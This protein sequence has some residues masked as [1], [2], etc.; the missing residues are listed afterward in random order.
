MTGSWECH[1]FEHPCRGSFVA[2]VYSYSAGYVHFSSV[3]PL[4]C[5][6]TR[7]VLHGTCRGY[8]CCFLWKLLFGRST[9]QYVCFV[10]FFYYSFVYLTLLTPITHC[11]CCIQRGCIQWACATS[12]T[13]CCCTGTWIDRISYNAS[14]PL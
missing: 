3:T 8:D 12:E 6:E 14:Q 11:C 9:F 1:C 7:G 2:W 13:I 5:K 4:W 10:C